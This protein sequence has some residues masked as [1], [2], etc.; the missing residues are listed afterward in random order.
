MNSPTAESTQTRTRTRDR[1]DAAAWPGVTWDKPRE[2]KCNAKLTKRIS[3]GRG[4][5]CGNAAGM[6]TDHVGIGQCRKHGGATR[7]HRRAASKELAR[8]E[9]RKLGLAHGESRTQVGPAQAML[10]ALWAAH[11]DL[12]LYGELVAELDAGGEGDS[13]LFSATYHL[14]GEETGEAKRHVLVQLYEDAQKRTAD[15]A[16]ACLRAKVAEEQVKLAQERASA[17]AEAM[18][19]LAQQL[20]HNPADPAVRTAMRAA[21]QIAASG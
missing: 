14:T 21:L 12:S 9:A 10:N 18:R 3:A 19:M 13:D 15:I 2:G 6:G 11:E 16:A 5:L 8:R 7:N 4:R 1:T 20:G 17:F